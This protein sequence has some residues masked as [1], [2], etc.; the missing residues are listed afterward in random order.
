MAETTNLELASAIAD[1]L[2]ARIEARFTVQP[3]LT[4]DQAATSL[5]LSV[6]KVRQLCTSGEIPHIRVD[7]FYRIK[8]ADVNAYLERNYHHR[9]RN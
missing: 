9:K 1:N 5:G 4:L 2:M 8:P 6:D 7:K 3:T